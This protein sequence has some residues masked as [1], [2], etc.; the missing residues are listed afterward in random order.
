[1]GDDS[2]TGDPAGRRLQR[3]RSQYLA[4]AGRIARALSAVLKRAAF[5][6]PG[7]DQPLQRLT[8]DER[9]ALL[10]AEGR[11]EPRRRFQGGEPQPL[12][13][14]R[15][16]QILFLDECGQ[17]IPRPDLA[18]IPPGHDAWIVGNDTF[19]GLEFRSA[20]QYAKPK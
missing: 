19:L 8:D 15:S 5:L 14:R 7:L 13:G 4:E 9:A 1:M 17:S 3:R 12:L 16:R 2:I 18:N 10:A 6:D 11:I 20:D